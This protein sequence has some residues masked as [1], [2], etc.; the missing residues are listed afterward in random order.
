PAPVPVQAFTPAPVSMPPVE[1]PVPEMGSTQ[2]ISGDSLLQDTA[3]GIKVT[4]SPEEDPLKNRLQRL[5]NIL[6]E[7]TSDISTKAKKEGVEIQGSKAICPNCRS[8]VIIMSKICPNC[9]RPL[10]TCPNCNAAITLFAR[11]CPSCGSL[12]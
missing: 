12:L 9:Q 2:K 8:L 11:I 7:T 4:V 3:E 5:S 10:R 1:R 6:E